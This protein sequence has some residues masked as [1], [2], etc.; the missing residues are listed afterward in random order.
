VNI[1][2][3]NSA[4]ISG[5]IGLTEKIRSTNLKEVVMFK[6]SLAIALLAGIAAGSAQAADHK[7]WCTDAHMAQMDADIAKMTDAKMK[8]SAQKHLDMSK[9]AMKKSDTAGCVKHMEETHKAMGM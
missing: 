1:C 4:G 5:V 9:A 7:D 8:K 6:A 2:F 3:K